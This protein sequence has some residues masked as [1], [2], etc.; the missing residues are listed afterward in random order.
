MMISSSNCRPRNSAGRFF[1]IRFK[2]PDQ[3]SVDLQQIRKTHRRVRLLCAYSSSLP[4]SFRGRGEAPG[5]LVPPLVVEPLL[6]RPEAHLR[7]FL[8]QLCDI[9][10]EALLV[11]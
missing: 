7:I 5:A 9:R 11:E 3:A 6:E 1:R 4:K 8:V 10:V 2:L